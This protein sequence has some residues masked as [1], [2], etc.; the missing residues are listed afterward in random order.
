MSLVP[1]AY[2][3]AILGIL[4]LL[5]SLLVHGMAIKDK[6]FILPEKLDSVKVYYD[7]DGFS[8]MK[9]KKIFILPSYAVSKDLRHRSKEELKAYLKTGFLELK[10]MSDQTYKIEGH[11]RGVGAGPFLGMF[12]GITTGIV[13]TVGTLACV[14]AAVPGGPIAMGAAGAAGV[15]ATTKAVIVVTAAGT[16]A[17]TP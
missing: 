2:N 5:S 9:N 15:A 10:R 8:V 4:T 3:R 12:L 11:Q 1:A 6:H 17:P 14:I 7:D 16:A 13:G